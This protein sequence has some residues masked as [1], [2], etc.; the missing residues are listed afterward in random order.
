MAVRM[1]FACELCGARPDGAT[2]RGLHEQLR[3]ARPG[4]YLDAHPG[5][6]LIWS[7]GGLYGRPRCACPSHREDLTA[8]LRA[9]YG[10]LG[11][12]VWD[13]EP[14]AARRAEP[15]GATGEPATAG[16]TCV[17]LQLA[18]AAQFGRG[19]AAATLHLLDDHARPLFGLADGAP[20]DQ[21]DRLL[22][23]MCD[24]LRFEARDGGAPDDLLLPCVLR[25]RRAHP[26]MLA[27]V[28]HE[29]AARAGI[30]T[31][32][33]SSP[34]RWYLSVPGGERVL[35][36]DAGLG[37]GGDP[38]AEVLAHCRHEVAYCTLTGLSRSFSARGRLDD[39]RR[40]TRMKL[41][42]PVAD[43]LHADARR[44]LDALGG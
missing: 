22:W 33:C 35:L 19:D 3:A 17:D 40:A 4:V 24:D 25:S 12:A 10:T 39:A 23:L 41:T 18:I 21:A 42:L 8:R 27:I 36:L 20:E 11:R 34:R 9:Q 6:W 29:L 5:G 38:P 26:L 43:R 31:T 44:E 13:S 16:A 28:A 37:D 15:P 1:L 14:H 2:R 7:G 32:V 30:R